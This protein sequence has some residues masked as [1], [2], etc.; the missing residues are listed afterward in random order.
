MAAI[1]KVSQ[2]PSTEF[3]LSVE[4]RFAIGFGARIPPK[5]R[6]EEFIVEQVEYRLSKLDQAAANCA[7]VVCVNHALQ[8][9][10]P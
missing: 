7:V 10:L 1:D 3:R 6:V 2:R 9:G 8:K 5:L 4:K